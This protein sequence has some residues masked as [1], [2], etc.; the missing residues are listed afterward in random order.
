M[1][2]AVSYPPARG[3]ET[4]LASTHVTGEYS[5]HFSVKVLFPTVVN[6]F[7]TDF[8]AFHRV[9]ILWFPFALFAVM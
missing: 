4:L 9:L 3:N 2:G 7:G 8:V 5:S 6:A 1:T